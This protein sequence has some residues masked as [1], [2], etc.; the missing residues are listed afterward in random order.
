MVRLRGY[1]T[2]FVQIAIAADSFEV[3]S[4]ALTFFDTFFTHLVNFEDNRIY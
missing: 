4:R 2:A 3:P 1:K